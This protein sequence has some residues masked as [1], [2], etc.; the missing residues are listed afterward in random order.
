MSDGMTIK[1]VSVIVCCY[2]S[3]PRLEET[4]RA[5]A[6]QQV[7]ARIL[8][9]VV[10]VNNASTDNTAELAVTLWE[11]YN[12]M[13]PL[14]VVD[15]PKPGQGHARNKG[16]E[17]ATY[18]ILLF[19]DDDNW[20][21]PRYIQGMYA[22]LQNDKRIAAC[23]G[24]GIPVFETQQPVWFEEY[25]E[26][27]ATGA[28]DINKEDDRIFNLYGAGMAIQRQAWNELYASG[29][30]ALTT[31]RV[32]KALSSADDTE[33]TYAFALMGYK[34]YYARDLRFFHYLP[35]QR[36]SFAYLKKLFV[37]FGTDG[38]IRNLY[39]AHLS[40]RPYHKK[41]INW[42]AHFLLSL[43]RLVKYLVV[44]PKKYGR[45]IYFNWSVAYIKTLWKIR[46]QYPQLVQRISAIK[47]IGR[48]RSTPSKKLKDLIF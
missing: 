5:L 33:L 19:C 35:K 7:E 23:G 40:E 37:A 15:E 47:L 25:K 10:L 46:R 39:Y 48:Q 18:S 13:V 11:K 3:V 4:L 20:L 22:I 38:P 28:Q 12:G 2:N 24:T 8:W 34:L 42:N 6:A 31:G 32:G 45:L 16:I 9:E 29:F 17:E 30:T 26:A 27:Y 36:L 1:G 44:P 21:N 41:L 14:R 43:V